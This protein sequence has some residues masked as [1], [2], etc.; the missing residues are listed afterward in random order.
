MDVPT[1]LLSVEER[2]KW[3][4]RVDRLRHSLTEVRARR[5]RLERQL[6]ALKRDLAKLGE[7]AAAPLEAAGRRAAGVEGGRPIPRIPR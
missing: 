4:R 6:K 1:I 7:I 2:E 5:V 3:G